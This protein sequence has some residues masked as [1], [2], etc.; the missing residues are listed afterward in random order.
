MLMPCNANHS[1]LLVEICS[2]HPLSQ[3]RFLADAAI[4]TNL[5]PVSSFSVIARVRVRSNPGNRKL[6]R[7]IIEVCAVQHG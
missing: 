2:A 4:R 7:H 1:E 6:R 3:Y 5:P